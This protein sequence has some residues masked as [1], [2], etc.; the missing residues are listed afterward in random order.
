MDLWMNSLGHNQ[1]FFNLIAKRS[2][3]LQQKKNIIMKRKALLIGSP[4]SPFLNGVE[5]DIKNVANFLKS[6]NGGSWKSSEIIITKYDPS[7]AEVEK[8]LIAFENLDFSFVYYSGHGYTDHNG[9]GHV[10]LNS[11]HRPSIDQFENRARRQITIIDACRGYSEY[12][13]FDGLAAPAIDIIPFDYEKPESSRII[14][15]NYLRSCARGSVLLH[16]AQKGQNAQDTNMGGYFSSNLLMATL[17]LVRETSNPVVIVKEIFHQAYTL[18]KDKHQPE[19]TYTDSNALQ[20]PFAIKSN[21]YSYE[22]LTERKLT[23]AKSVNNNPWG[24]VLKVGAFAGIA[25]L[26]GKILWRKQ[27]KK[28]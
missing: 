16:A 23:S 8:H 27:D 11:M 21:L 7:F 13:S 17:K 28:K 15:D 14:F 3:T 19:I 20:L 6:S 26:I 2:K 9:I 12:A 10:N 24:T 22:N 1:C 4:G 5:L 18:T 25:Y